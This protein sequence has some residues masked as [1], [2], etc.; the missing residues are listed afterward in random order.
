MWY[1]GCD[2]T[3]SDTVSRSHQYLISNT[4]QL[5]AHNRWLCRVTS[6][7]MYKINVEERTPKV[8]DNLSKVPENFT[9]EQYLSNLHLFYY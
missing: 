7:L 8:G 1:F 6:V 5:M 3:S 4:S 2:A 9:Q